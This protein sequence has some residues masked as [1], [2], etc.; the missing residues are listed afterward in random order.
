MKTH[1]KPILALV[2]LSLVVAAFVVPS[3]R[4]AQAAGTWYVAPPPTGSDSNDCLTPSTPCATINGAIAKGASGDT[5]KVAMGTYVGMDNYPVVVSIDK[6]VSLSGGWD[7][8]FTTQEGRSTIDG[9]NLRRG[10]PYT[11]QGSI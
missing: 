7:M 10:D 5:I 6:S 1:S 11:K 3:S 9:E 2:L 4:P 8:G